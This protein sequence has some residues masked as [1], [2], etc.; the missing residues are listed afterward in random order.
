MPVFAV[1]RA[2]VYVLKYAVQRR[3]GEILAEGGAV[4]VSSAAAAKKKEND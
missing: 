4:A 2:L 1:K 3:V